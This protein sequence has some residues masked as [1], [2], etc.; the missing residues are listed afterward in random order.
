MKIR[1][2][3]QGATTN[4]NIWWIFIH[5]RSLLLPCKLLQ[6][7]IIVWYF[8]KDEVKFNLKCLTTGIE[9]LKDEVYFPQCMRLSYPKEKHNMT[10]AAKM[11][12]IY[13]MVP[14]HRSTIQYMTFSVHWTISPRGLNWV[15]QAFDKTIYT[16]WIA[17]GHPA[18]LQAR[19]KLQIPGLLGNL[20]CFSTRC[21]NKVSIRW[22][23]CHV[24]DDL[25]GTFNSSCHMLQALVAPGLPFLD[26]CRSW[27]R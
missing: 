10:E 23:L 27:V 3:G 25:L 26:Y 13:S 12:I 20:A 9:F 16:T 18:F 11:A 19:Y 7:C 1:K 22:C 5:L 14:V 4:A 17:T 15:V 2:P 24:S 21:S 6:F 8:L